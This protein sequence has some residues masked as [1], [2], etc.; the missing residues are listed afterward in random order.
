MQTVAII[1]RKGGTG[2]TTLA[3]SLA[4]AAQSDGF[5][6]VILDMDPQGSA[7][8]WWR[9]RGKQPPSVAA[10]RQSA[11]RGHLGAAKDAGVDV[12][13]VDTAPHVAGTASAVAAAADFVLVSCRPGLLD[14]AAITGS[15]AIVQ[16]F[17]KPFAV[18][19]NAA[20]IR[21]PLIAQAHEALVDTGIVVAPVVH[22]RVGH[23]YAVTEGLAAAER[24]PGSKA[25]QEI[26]QLWQWLL[27]QPKR[28]R[29]KK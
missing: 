2:K 28:K 4:V 27:R 26:E 11:L 20:P 5:V 12:V 3:C 6:A 8:A 29:R 15:V 25:A 16:E 14:L 7:K 9:V 21:S 23:A 19:L 24:E 10:T 18:V 17:S 1:S 22:Q 13:F